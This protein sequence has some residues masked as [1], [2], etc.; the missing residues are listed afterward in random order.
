MRKIKR[1]GWIPDIPDQR[2]FLFAAPPVTL[3]P[4]VDLRTGCPDVYDQGQLG[5]CTANAI[6]GAI[7]FAQM[8]ENANAFVPSR[9][10]VYWNERDIEHTVASDAGAQ[11]RDGIKVVV[12]IGAPVETDWPYVIAKF[13]DRPPQKAFVDA[14]KNIVTS[15]QRV[16]QNLRQ[17]QGCLASGFPFVFG[18]TVY[19]G[20]ESDQ[21]A[22]TGIVP[23]PKPGESALG[24]H[25]V[26]AVGYDDSTQRF[27]VRNSW[28]AVWGQKGYFEMPYAYLTDSNLSDDLWTIRVVRE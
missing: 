10:F 4:K 2:D 16:S 18:F 25:A 5:S 6:N 12:K 28:G 9:L 7:E 22:Q 19:D 20:F 21:V 24:G 8:K 11:I 13:A 26:M 3:P 23:M 17:M 15:Y 14:R 27:I 1:Y